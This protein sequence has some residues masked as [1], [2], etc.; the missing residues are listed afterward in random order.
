MPLK[1]SVCMK[2]NFVSFVYTVVFDIK[3]ACKSSLSLANHGGG[4]RLANFLQENLLVFWKSQNA[5]GEIIYYSAAGYA[6]SSR[7]TVAVNTTTSG[8]FHGIF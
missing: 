1:F 3:T 7:F 6:W 4:C 5:V 2:S 8:K